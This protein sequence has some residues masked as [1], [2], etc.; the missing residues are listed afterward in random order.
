MTQPKIREGLP[1]SIAYGNLIN[2]VQE[3]DDNGNPY[4]M[5]YFTSSQYMPSVGIVLTHEQ[6]LAEHSKKKPEAKP[7]NLKFKVTNDKQ[8]LTIGLEIGECYW[9]EYASGQG[10][11]KGNDGRH[12]DY[13]AMSVREISK[14]FPQRWRELV[15]SSQHR[16]AQPQPG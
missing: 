7:Y 9:I 16:Q 1:L 14:H 3:V 15:Q 13:Q 8:E 6:I 10:G 11:L 4:V 2:F 5:L 12:V